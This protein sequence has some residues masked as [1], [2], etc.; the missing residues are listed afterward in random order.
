MSAR[1]IL[2]ADQDKRT[3]N[4]KQSLRSV[5]FGAITLSRGKGKLPA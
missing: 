2:D 1:A 5:S 4:R 3:V